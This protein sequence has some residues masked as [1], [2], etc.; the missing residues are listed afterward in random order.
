MDDLDLKTIILSTIY[1]TLCTI[2]AQFCVV[3]S[4]VTPYQFFLCCLSYAFFTP[5]T[6]LIIGLIKGIIK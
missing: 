1:I 6:T 4:A 3:K 2:F 5:L